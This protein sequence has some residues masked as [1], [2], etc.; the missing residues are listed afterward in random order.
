MK[1]IK[2]A[3]LTQA[4]QKWDK[5]IGLA[6]GKFI[7]P[8]SD[9]DPIAFDSFVADFKV[10]FRVPSN[11]KT[12]LSHFY[13]CQNSFS[14]FSKKF[15]KK[16]VH[17]KIGPRKSRKTIKNFSTGTRKW[18]DIHQ[19]ETF[20]NQQVTFSSFYPSVF[21]LAIITLINEDRSHKHSKKHITNIVT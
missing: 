15:Q 12:S 1:W 17:F 20:L 11:R 6:R 21:I 4:E 7:L 9:H 8:P 10:F 13:F 5:W 16:K 18:E 3:I 19:I 2:R 14:F